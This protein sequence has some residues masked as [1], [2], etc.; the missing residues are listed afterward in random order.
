MLSQGRWRPNF[1]LSREQQLRLL[2]TFFSLEHTY[3]G[4]S[5]SKLTILRSQR[6]ILKVTTHWFWKHAF[7]QRS[8]HY[9]VQLPRLFRGEAI[10]VT[11]FCPKFKLGSKNFASPMLMRTV[12]DWILN[13][14][15]CPLFREILQLPSNADLHFIITQFSPPWKTD[16][17]ILNMRVLISLRVMLLSLHINR[18]SFEFASQLHTLGDPFRVERRCPLYS[19]FRWSIHQ[20]NRRHSPRVSQQHKKLLARFFKGSAFAFWVPKRDSKISSATQPTYLRR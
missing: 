14:F 16:H 3:R 9:S 15:R 8:N 11:D 7:S 12:K 17:S 2:S 13:C 20:I 6:N 10:E 1:Q 5:P 4:I 19:L 18:A